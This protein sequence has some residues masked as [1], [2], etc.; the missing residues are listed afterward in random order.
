MKKLLLFLIAFIALS[1]HFSLADDGGST[2]E[3]TITSELRG[4]VDSVWPPLRMPPLKR[5]IV[6]HYANGVIRFEC[7]REDSY[8]VKVTHNITTKEWTSEINSAHPT[9]R[10]EVIPG[11]YNIEAWTNSNQCFV[12][13]LKL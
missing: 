7:A 5:S 11:I 6:F 8:V 12:G 9:M 4:K 2:P 13:E 10:I 3:T 1:V